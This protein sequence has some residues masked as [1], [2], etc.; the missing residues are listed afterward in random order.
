[1]S[2]KV[3]SF[4]IILRMNKNANSLISDLKLY[5]SNSIQFLNSKIYKITLIINNSVNTEEDF[6]SNGDNYFD[7]IS[8][9]IKM[10]SDRSPYLR[11]YTNK[12][13]FIGI[14]NNNKYIYFGL[15][16]S[17]ITLKLVHSYSDAF[18]KELS[19]SV[20]SGD[21]G[22]MTSQHNYIQRNNMRFSSTI[23]FNISTEFKIPMNYITIL[24][25]DKVTS[26]KI[27]RDILDLDIYEVKFLENGSLFIRLVDIFDPYDVDEKYVQSYTTL[28]EYLKSK[29]QK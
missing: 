15:S 28:Y 13:S 27:E 22:I 3:P 5:L 10:G 6:K 17:E 2:K 7:I 12:N 19:T 16:L 20:Y 23:P 1:M 25:K 4:S 11:F 24:D 26:L 18:F 9:L 29:Q 14:Q 21:V 8:K